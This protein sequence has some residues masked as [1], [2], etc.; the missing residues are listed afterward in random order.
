MSGE[1]K[2]KTI[3]VIGAGYWG[4]NLVRNYFE[5]GVLH[6]VCDARAE[7]LS[8]MQKSFPDVKLSPNFEEVLADKEVKAVVIAL[9]AESHYEYAA[10]ALQAGKDVFVEKPLA[11]DL[12]HAK[13]LN[14]IALEEKRILMVGHLLRYHPAFLKLKGLIDEGV[15][16]RIQYLYSTRLSLGKIRREENALWS[17]APHD[18]SMIL[19]LCNEMPNHVT[20]VGH[21]Y[22]HKQLA[23]VT[24]THLSFPSGINSHIFVSWLHPFKEQK[25]IVIGEAKMAVFE[26]TQPWDKKIALYSHTIKWQSGMPIPEKADPEF[27]PLEEKEPLREECLHFLQCIEKRET[28]LTDGNEGYRVL[29][30]LRRAQ[31]SLENAAHKDQ[32]IDRTISAMVEDRSYFAHESACID[33][34]CQIGAGTKIWHGSHVMKGAQIGEKC[35]L[36]QNVCIGNDVRIGDNVKIQNNVSVYTGTEIESDVFLGPSCVLTNIT[37]PRSQIVRHSLYEKTL[38]KRGATVGANATIVC[39]ITIGRYAFIAAGAVV[40]EDV[41]DYALMVGVPARQKGWMSRHGIKLPSPDRDGIMV[42]LESNFRYKEISKGELKC[43]DLDEEKPLPA[44]MAV[45]RLRYDELKTRECS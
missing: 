37:N 43:L 24:T 2:M 9:P 26:D 38:I 23:D 39:G 13:K 20:A 27:V 29:E 45:G 25:L 17:F 8:A 18:I 40:A 34:P 11:L 31:Q 21:N 3:A 44:G 41:P 15:L 4:K 16:G 42:C 28:P 6:S 19:A 32:N 7:V 14:A 36:G 33:A 22:L 35:I 30:V 10:K 12:D 1:R 5:L